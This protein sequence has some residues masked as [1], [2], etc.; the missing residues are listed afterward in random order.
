M[1]IAIDALGGDHAPEAPVVGALQAL[2]AYPDVEVVLVGDPGPIE[3]A[4]A[5]HG[6][7]VSDRLSIHDAP[8]SPGSEDPVKAIRR[9][10]KVSARACADLLHAG[11]VQGVVTMG[12][13]GAAVAAATLYCRRL[14]GVKRTGIAVPLPTPNG[15]CI[16]I[17]GGAN[18]DAKATHLHQYA[19]MAMH[20][21]TASLGIK[22]PR[23][24]ILSIGE[25]ES[26]G[27]RLVAETWELFRENPLPNFIGN[28]EP[29]AVFEG[30]ADVI[31]CDGFT[32][33]IVLKT[34]EGMASFVMKG[35][36]AALAAAG[37]E[38]DP[39]SMLRSLMTALDYAQYGGAPLLGV[40]GAYVIG[41]G[42][43]GPEAYKN[44]VRVIRSYIEGNVGDRIVEQLAATKASGPSSTDEA[45]A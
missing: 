36:P 30:G 42:R 11:T 43:S 45:S 40:E 27:N 4:L 37:I 9:S 6:A 17:D 19:V 5:A 26:K 7:T 10:A 18:P 13:T 31:V 28:I 41:H 3:A 2:E 14:P 25:E 12:T 33:N 44:G 38:K 34:A 35:V 21:A 16:C 29:H 15:V 20:Y 22:N 32:G 8:E 24:A 23:I 1:Q 39:R